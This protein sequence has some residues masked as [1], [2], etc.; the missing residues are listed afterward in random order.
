MVVS[1]RTD[2]YKPSGKNIHSYDVNS[3]Y[4]TSMRNLPMAVGK[5]NYFEGDIL[6][7][8]NLL[9]INDKPLDSLK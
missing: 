9:K 4:P 8:N 7:L 5:V 2:V 3:L 6:S 1:P